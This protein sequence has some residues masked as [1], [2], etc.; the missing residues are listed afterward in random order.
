[1]RSADWRRLAGAMA[2]IGVLSVGLGVGSG[3]SV[4]QQR[5]QV[6]P[7]AVDMHV[8]YAA[9]VINI[10]AR[11]DFYQSGGTAP[12]ANIVAGIV[13]AITDAWNGHK[14]K[15]FSVVVSVDARTTISKAGVRPDAVDVKLDRSRL[16]A[17][18]HVL[19]AASNNYLS[20]DPADRQTSGRE[21]GAETMDPT[22]WGKYTDA[23]V[24]AHE[25]GHVL[26]LHDSY[27]PSD[28]SKV[29]P[30]AQTD[31]MYSQQYPISAEMITR[32]IRRNNTGQLDESKI[33]CPLSMDAGPASVNMFFIEVSGLGMHAYTCDFDA[34]SDDPARKAK[35]ISWTGQA[36]G[37]G[38]Y[39]NPVFGSSS[40]SYTGPIA[41]SSEAN[42][43]YKFSLVSPSGHIDFGGTYRWGTKGVPVNIG[44]MTLFGVPSSAVGLGLYPVF[45]EG[46][47]ECP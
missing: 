24:W 19:G 2:V 18:S 22:T 6:F 39:N 9:R 11:V 35:P 4:A 40:G 27:D 45:S 41:F 43:P 7:V 15:C 38:T 1:M 29:L 34:P 20:D 23:N 14:F 47:S 10:T 32:I 5:G 26:G 3:T 44:S 12:D 8:D 30:G 16:R 37:S 33:K 42:V 28:N 13:K 46:A 31:M 21:T 25:F 36:S 17:L